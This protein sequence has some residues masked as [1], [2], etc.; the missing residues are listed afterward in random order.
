MDR[1]ASAEGLEGVRAFMRRRFPALAER[2]LTEARVCQYENSA[3]GDLLIDRHPGLA[4][5]LL[6]G[7]GSGHGFKHGP[8]VGR[9]AADLLMGRLATPEPRFSLASKGER[10]ARAVH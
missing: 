2:P 1:R 7:G 6:V 3:N 9:Y 8:A 10:E 4:N 5:V